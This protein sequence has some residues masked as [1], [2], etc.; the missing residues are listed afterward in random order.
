MLQDKVEGGFLGGL[1]DK[2]EAHHAKALRLLAENGTLWAKLVGRNLVNPPAADGKAEPAVKIHADLMAKTQA[3][4]H[5]AVAGD[6]SAVSIKRKVHK[7]VNL[8][9]AIFG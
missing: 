5:S 6:K 4:V 3:H 9:D 1:S 2:S 8:L 7:P